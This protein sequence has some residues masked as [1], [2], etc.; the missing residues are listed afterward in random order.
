VSYFAWKRDIFISPLRHRGRGLR[1]EFGGEEFLR[2]PVGVTGQ[3]G[4][5]GKKKVRNSFFVLSQR[6]QW[7]AASVVTRENFTAVLQCFLQKSKFLHER[8]TSKIFSKML[9]IHWIFLKKCKT[10][11]GPVERIFSNDNVN[12]Y[13]AKKMHFSFM[14]VNL[15][16]SGHHHVS[17]TH[18]S[19]FRVVRTR[20]Q[21]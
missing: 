12:W 14:D 6:G 3:A 21:I 1:V 17:A 16:H 11:R 2:L 18:V 4:A 8:Q 15:L 9:K 7:R 5:P 10:A 13:V 20:I 19:V